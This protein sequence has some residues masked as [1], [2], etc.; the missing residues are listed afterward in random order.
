MPSRTT[1]LRTLKPFAKLADH[2]PLGI[3]D[4][5]HMVLYLFQDAM[6]VSILA[7]DLRRAAR[8]YAKVAKED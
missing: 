1:L 6:P 2:I 4:D 3:G 5:V 7:G 8:L